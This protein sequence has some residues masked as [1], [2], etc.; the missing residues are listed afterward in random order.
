[1]PIS[2]RATTRPAVGPT[3]APSDM[4]VIPGSEHDLAEHR[5]IDALTAEIAGG[6]TSA[7]LLFAR[8]LA[9]K[10][11]GHLDEALADFTK[12]LCSS[13]LDRDR[14]GRTQH[15]RA[16]CL[17]RLGALDQALE[18][19]DDA[20]TLDPESPSTWGHRGYVQS[21]SGRQEAALADYDRSF[22][23]DPDATAVHLFRGNGWVWHG[24]YTCALRD[25]ENAIQRN[26]NTL[27]FSVFHNRGVARMLSGDPLGARADFDHA[28]SLRPIDAFHPLDPRTLACRGLLNTLEGRLEDA[29]RDLHESSHLGFASVG[30][31]AWALLEAKCGRTGEITALGRSFALDYHAGA[32][33]GMASFASML[34][35]PASMLPELQAI[36]G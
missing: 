22:R 30:V 34:N 4:C 3:T 16:V 26:R 1:M 35:D 23:I 17:R 20:V 32:E 9:H 25:Y 15:F 8:G 11:L 27:A 31:V 29:R 14:H 36:I 7:A 5:R 2:A 13:G 12:V 21:C 6:D 24:D 33:V 19:A 10:Q 28:E 18:A